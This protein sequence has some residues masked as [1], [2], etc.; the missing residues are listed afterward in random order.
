MQTH[1]LR[2]QN[3]I[4][5]GERVRHPLHQINNT[6]KIKQNNNKYKTT[7]LIIGSNNREKR[8]D[9]ERRDRKRGRGEAGGLQGAA[10][11]PRT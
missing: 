8:R 1:I 3:K 2:T 7:Q 4:K 9:M 11:P 6:N 10:L 5:N